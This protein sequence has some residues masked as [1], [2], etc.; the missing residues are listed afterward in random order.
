MPFCVIYNVVL[1]NHRVQKSPWGRRSIS[2]SR[3]KTPKP[4]KIEKFRSFI[5]SLKKGSH[6]SEKKE[7]LRQ[8]LRKKPTFVIGHSNQPSHVKTTL[9]RPR[10]GLVGDITVDT[11]GIAKLLDG[12]IWP[13]CTEWQSA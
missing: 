3:S 9:T 1:E 11:K 10:K 2:S 4:E 13:G 12:L 8:I 7:F 5:K 6:H